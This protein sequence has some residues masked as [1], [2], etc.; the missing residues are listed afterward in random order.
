MTMN[1]AHSL[2]ETSRLEV[3][4]VREPGD[5]AGGV[6]ERP[7][8]SC[9]NFLVHFHALDWSDLAYTRERR[10]E[11]QTPT[12]PGRFPAEVAD[13]L[14][15]GGWKD[16]MVN[17]A[18]AAGAIE[19][20]CE[21]AGQLHRHEPFPAAR[22]ALT[23]FPAVYSHRR[24]PG[25]EVW[26][27]WFNTNPTRAAHSADTLADFGAVLGRRLFPL[28]AEGQDSIIA[29]DEGAGCSCW[30]RPASGSSATTSTP[31]SPPCCSAAPPPGYATTAPG[32]ATTAR[33]SA[34]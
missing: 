34:P 14:M 3:H 19:D 32:S 26:I 16:T 12:H 28:G 6:A 31:P 10:P 4:Q 29:I 8:D 25:Q 7:C 15:D 27:S 2:L 5:P 33:R 21:V 23:A 18:L 13:S 30:T 17:P 11:S 22:A 24:G 9:V 1:D 20:T